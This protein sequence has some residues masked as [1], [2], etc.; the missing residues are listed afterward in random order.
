MI[1]WEVLRAEQ[2]IYLECFRPAV[3]FI[4]LIWA[5]IIFYSPVLMIG[6]EVTEK[7]GAD[8]SYPSEKEGKAL[9]PED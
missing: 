9:S 1:L 8:G 2:M 6:G 7:G 4:I 3:R 5:G